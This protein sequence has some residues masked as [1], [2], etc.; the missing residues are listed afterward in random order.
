M[1]VCNVVSNLYGKVTSNCK[2]KSA[3]Y[4]NKQLLHIYLQH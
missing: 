3:H 4:R 1:Q 2:K